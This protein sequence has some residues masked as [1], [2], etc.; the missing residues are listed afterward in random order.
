M[1]QSD[2]GV[3]FC[4][5]E[6]LLHPDYL[7]DMLK[8]CGR[9]GIHRTVDTTLLARKETIDEVM[10]HCEQ[11]LIDL[12][13]MS[14]AVNKTFCDVPNELILEK[15]RRVTETDFPYYI[16][17]LLIDG[18]NADKENII[19]SAAFLKELPRHPEIINL[20]LSQHRKGRA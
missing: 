12:K 4:E 13:S 19:R 18:I 6:P 16:R 11:L 14:S 3:T 8:R 10:K 20:L 9:L 17:I 5:G 7:I 1:D 15:I 2:G